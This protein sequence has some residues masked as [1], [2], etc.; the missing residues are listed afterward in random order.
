MNT[1][2]HSAE[3]EAAL[4]RA[5]FSAIP[6]ILIGVGQDG[7]ITLWNRATEKAFCIM[8][9][10]TVGKQLQECPIPWDW[11]KVNERL[12]EYR[13]T[14]KQVRM[15]DVRFT[16]CGGDEGFLGLTLN[17]MQT[18][19]DR[20]GGF[21]LL[22][23]DIT[24]RRMLERQLYQA[25]K[26][27]SIGRLAAGIAHEINTPMQYIG[28]NTRFLQEMISEVGTLL[29][30][31]EELLDA[32]KA[33]TLTPADVQ[34]VREATE[35]AD[36]EYLM[37]EA[38]KAIQQSLEGIER[39]T[40]IVQAMK[41]FSHPG[42]EQKVAINI[43]RAIESTIT[44][45]R[46][47]WK[48]VAELETDFDPDLPLVPCLPGEFNQVILNLVINSAHAIS[49]VV[50]NQPGAKGKITLATR[51]EGDWVE[52]RVADTGGG[53][54]EAIRGKVFDPFYTTKE[55][56]KGTGQ[57]LALAHSSVVDKHGGSIN[58]ESQEG[59]GTTFIIRLPLHTAESANQ[60]A[61]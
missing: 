57:G 19:E 24:Q 37:E 14:G 51:R 7:R 53:I 3:Q 31:Y 17:P 38:P 18:P 59:K 42:T 36:A 29:A 58:F 13:A 50:T 41:E 23:A 22:G 39:V 44:V 5:V 27:E 20:P 9:D 55:V 46:N 16:R 40:R 4:T 34:K 11:E 45:A 47:E 60:K 32:A 52:V 15:D 12:E 49:D 28:D 8:A 33:G 61:A 48:Y 6:S 2:P 10:A 43:N 35:A 21:L 30:A 1:H 54:P 56:G 25:Q 26:M